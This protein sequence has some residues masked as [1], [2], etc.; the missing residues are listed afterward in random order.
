MTGP[1]L[2][3]ASARERTV[4]ARVEHERAARQRHVDKS[5]S[6]A[7]GEGFRADVAWG[8]GL[9]APEQVR[10]PGTA[11]APRGAIPLDPAVLLAAA[12]VLAVLIRTSPWVGALGVGGVLAGLVAMTARRGRR[13]VVVVVHATRHPLT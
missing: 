1:S 8:P 12:V 6:Y 10:L 5:A 4:V 2:E 11:P 13:P 9:D 3:S 7:A